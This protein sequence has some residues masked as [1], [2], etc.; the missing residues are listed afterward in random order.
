ML[1]TPLPPELTALC[2]RAQKACDE[3]AETHRQLQDTR[4]QT[5]R[6]LAQARQLQPLDWC[7]DTDDAVP[8]PPAEPDLKDTAHEAVH[9][10]HA[11]LQT[12]PLRW[13]IAIV[14][15]LGAGTAVLA[16]DRRE[17]RRTL[18]A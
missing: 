16:Q 4:A 12:F 15:A 5:Q 6:L 13:Q 17:A 9:A 14:K 11:I 1:H 18:S 2:A 8:P 7:A 10:I 3:L